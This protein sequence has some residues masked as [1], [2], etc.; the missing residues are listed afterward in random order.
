MCYT[1]PAY[2][3]VA[4]SVSTNASGNGNATVYVPVPVGG[5][6]RPRQATGTNGAAIVRSAFINSPGVDGNV[7]SI[8][9]PD[10]LPEQEGGSGASTALARTATATG[11]AWFEPGTN[12]HPIAP[13][14]QQQVTV[15]VSGGPAST[16][17]NGTLTLEYLPG[18]G[19][20]EKTVVP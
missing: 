13:A 4:F 8:T 3:S 9:L 12:G 14:G 15:A 1:S 10:A 6:L 18:S 2:I 11:Y 20:L 17:V 19:Q 16:T 7:F 5:M